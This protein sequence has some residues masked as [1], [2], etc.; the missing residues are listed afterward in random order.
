MLFRSNPSSGMPVYLQLIAQ[1][2]H[3]IDVGALKPGEQL[4][5]IRKVAE[6]LVI[7]P[8]TVARAYRD[9]EQ[10]GVIE[11]RQGAGAFVA[12]AGAGTRVALVKKG[13]PVAQ[14]AVERLAALGLTPEEIRRLLDAEMMRLADQPRA[15]KP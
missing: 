13:Q 8:N 10:A 3:A 6:D 1:V 12:D 15:R 14:A 7:N 9:L 2:R 11:L 5:A 4:P